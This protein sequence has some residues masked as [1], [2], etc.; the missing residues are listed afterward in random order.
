MLHHQQDN[1]R[2]AHMVC[3][4]QNLAPSMCSWR[5]FCEWLRNQDEHNFHIRGCLRS[6]KWQQNSTCKSWRGRR[7]FFRRDQCAT[8]KCIISLFN[9]LMKPLRDG[10]LLLDLTLSLIACWPLR[11]RM[12][13]IF[14][15]HH[16]HYHHPIYISIFIVLRT[17]FV[18]VS[19]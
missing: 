8:P 19:N 16:H 2:S 11:G 17:M 14:I 15:D 9:E 18:Q 7:A 5:I 6:I 4:L 12:Q 3:S 13:R 10:S 1:D